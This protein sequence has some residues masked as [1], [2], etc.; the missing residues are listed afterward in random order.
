MEGFHLEGYRGAQQTLSRQHG[1]TLMGDPSQ[2]VQKFA[3]NVVLSTG[4][5]SDGGTNFY[6]YRS[7]QQTFSCQVGSPLKEGPISMGTKVDKKHCHGKGD[8]L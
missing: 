3:S 2:G 6:G 8:Q 1:L 7:A 4:V 5:N